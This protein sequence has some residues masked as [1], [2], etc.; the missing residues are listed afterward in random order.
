MEVQFFK[1]P[2]GNHVRVVDRDG[3]QAGTLPK[4]DMSNSS[5]PWVGWG[6]QARRELIPGVPPFRSRGLFALEEV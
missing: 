3:D 5:A 4:R 6:A 1:A 2:A